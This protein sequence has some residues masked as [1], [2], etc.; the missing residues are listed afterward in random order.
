FSLISRP[1]M[2]LGIGCFAA[3][4]CMSFFLGPAG[5][6]F[7]REKITSIL[8][9]RAPLAIEEG[10]FNTSF[11]D[12]VILVK[13]KPAPD[14]L[15]GIFIVDERKKDEPKV[16]VAKEGRIISEAD[17]LSF[18]LKGGHVYITNKNSLT[19]ITFG[20]YYFR[21]TPVLDQTA[22]KSSELSPFEL[23]SEAASNPDKKL[24]YLLEFHR[25]LSMPGVCLIII[26][27][28]PSLA[29]I[30][31][32]TGRLGGLTAGLLVF[33]A[34]YSVMIYGE[35]LARSGALPHFIGAWLSFVMLAAFSIY[36]FER[37]NK[38]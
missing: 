10:I 20:T 3:S 17:A 18:A 1:V 2:Y 13:D 7:L 26:F 24:S 30:A 32:K 37:V 38:K 8:V 4:L 27:L 36:A 14:R 15:S 23:I 25:R 34:Y 22:R 16:I 33:A 35:N 31:G 21:L 12:M 11:K 28:G 9:T 6:V 19:E 5:S 29:L